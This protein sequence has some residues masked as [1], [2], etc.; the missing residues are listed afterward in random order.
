MNEEQRAAAGISSN[1]PQMAGSG[2]H[3]A[4]P[5]EGSTPSP[6]LWLGGPPFSSLSAFL[7]TT[8]GPPSVGERAWSSV[9]IAVV[10]SPNGAAQWPQ[11]ALH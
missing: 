7:A 2:V 10:T 1:A 5:G 8:R 6:F 4:S 9:P 3:G 11:P